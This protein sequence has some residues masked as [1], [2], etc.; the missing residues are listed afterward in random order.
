[1]PHLNLTPARQP[2]RRLSNPGVAEGSLDFSRDP[3][4]SV[5]LALRN[6]VAGARGDPIPSVVLRRQA[7]QDALKAEIVDLR[8]WELGTKALVQA[9]RLGARL[10]DAQKNELIA[11]FHKRFDLPETLLRAALDRPDADELL[12]ISGEFGRELLPFLQNADDPFDALAKLRSNKIFMEGLAE[13]ADTRNF[14]VV[15][16]KLAALEQIL[17]RRQPGLLDSL[18]TPDGLIDL[19]M[20]DLLRLI[21]QLTQGNPSAALSASELGTLRRT[22]TEF[23]FVDPAIRHKAAVAAAGRVPLAEVE[24]R[25]EAAALGRGRAALATRPPPQLLGQEALATAVGRGQGELATRV[26]G[27]VLTAEAFA[28]KTGETRAAQLVEPSAEEVARREGLIAAAK[29]DPTKAITDTAKLAMGLLKDGLDPTRIKA[30]LSSSKFAGADVVNAALPDSQAEFLRDKEEN[31]IAALQ[32]R[33]DALVNAGVSR[34][35]ATILT[36][37]GRGSQ[38]SVD[39]SQLTTANRTAVQRDLQDMTA[40]KRQADQVLPLINDQ[41]VGLLPFIS[42]DIGGIVQNLPLARDIAEGLG[43]TFRMTAAQVSEAKTAAFEMNLLVSRMAA[44]IKGR[45][46][47][48][49]VQDR[50]FAASAMDLLQ[51][52]STPDAARKIVSRLQD[53]LGDIRGDLIGELQSGRVNTGGGNLTVE[54][55]GSG[56]YVV[57][58]QSGNIVQRIQRLK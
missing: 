48:I 27:H 55:D 45:G 51:A 13:Q 24:P 30:I 31:E 35:L 11:D 10:P 7:R 57:K 26:P 6:A 9:R 53:I 42:R 33:I 2:Q 23:G 12:T 32:P 56:G 37:G 18:R 54:P 1:M 44:F 15:G 14:P 38:V 40:L 16:K 52:T 47:R 43:R 58:D 8:R 3:L 39:P 19:S 41:T 50:E 20:P 5:G 46:G 29:R 25:A 34:E 4:G 22:P 28:R 17:N 49:A 36:L 21:E